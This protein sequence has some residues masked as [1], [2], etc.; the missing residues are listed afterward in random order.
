[1]PI[2]MEITDSIIQDIMLRKYNPH[3]KLPSENEL[4]YRFNIPRITARKIYERLEELG[5]IYKMQG[6]GS[7]VKDRYK[8]LELILSGGVSFSQKMLERGYNLYSQNVF[9][10]EI[11]YN[12]KVFYYLNIDKNDRVFKIGRLRFID[13]KPIALHISYTAQS[14]FPRIKE[15]GTDITSMFQYYQEQGYHEILAKQSILSVSFP[16]FTQQKLLKCNSLVPVLELETG[17]YDK[18]T[19]KVLEFTRILY[20]CDCFSYVI[21]SSG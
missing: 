15:D 10:K 2:E 16:T 5:Y 4:A 17:C 9:C 20:R 6:K 11:K 3:D 14:V 12:K 8:H 18:I 19:G 21:P 13:E 1:M 7:F